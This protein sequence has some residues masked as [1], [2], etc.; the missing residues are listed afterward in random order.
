MIKDFAN[1]AD[2]EGGQDSWRRSERKQSAP[3]KF[4]ILRAKHN[5]HSYKKTAR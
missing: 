3:I 2:S 1:L 5:F 4:F